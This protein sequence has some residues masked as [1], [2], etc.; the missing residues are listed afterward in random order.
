MSNVRSKIHS[1]TLTTELFAIGFAVALTPPTSAAF[2]GTLAT[3]V[4]AD[5]HILI[6]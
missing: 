5:R 6:G 4:R 1:R 3:T 2:A